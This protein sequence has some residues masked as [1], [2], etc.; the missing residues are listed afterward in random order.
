MWSR[1]QNLGELQMLLGRM[2]IGLACGAAFC[3]STLGEDRS[4]PKV[5]GARRLDNTIAR[6][7]GDG[8]NWHMTWLSDDRVVAGLCDGNARPW[9]NVPHDNYNSK[10]ISIRGVPPK[11]D[12]S[13]VRGYPQV[14][15]SPQPPILSR[16]YGFGILAV[17][18]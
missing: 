18:G 14:P 7:G 13:D 17:D 12:F 5:I 6:L 9:P 11:L 8:D 4:P 3:R 10:L 2:L 16:Y 15:G 1:N